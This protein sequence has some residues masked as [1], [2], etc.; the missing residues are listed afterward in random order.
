MGVDGEHSAE[1]GKEAL[2]ARTRGPN[3]ELQKVRAELLGK[4]ATARLRLEHAKQRGP[5]RAKLAKLSREIRKQRRQ[6]MAAS[7]AKLIE[8]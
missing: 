4:L 3:K 6:W 7:W 5:L 1:H 8:K 2:R